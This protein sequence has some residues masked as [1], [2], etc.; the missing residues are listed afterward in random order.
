MSFRCTTPLINLKKNP[1]YLFCNVQVRLNDF[2]VIET[3]YIATNLQ[4]KQSYEFRVCAINKAG[5]S[6]PSDGTAP[7][8]PKDPDGKRS[9]FNS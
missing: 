5:S 4:Q 3:S 2:P 9:L 7:V 6:K 8:T 1:N